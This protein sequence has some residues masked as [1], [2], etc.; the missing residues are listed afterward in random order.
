MTTA[1]IALCSALVIVEFVFVPLYLKKM[2]PI[3]NWGSLCY[4]M[5]CA[6][7][8]VLLAVT[9]TVSTGGA[10]KYSAVMLAGFAFSWLGDLMLHIPKPTRLFFLIGTFFFGMAHVFYCLAYVSAQKAYFPE[11]PMFY[12]WEITLTTAL[13]ITYFIVCLIRKVPFG[14]LIIPMVIYGFFV[15]MMTLKSTELAIRLLEA[16]GVK[17]IVPAILLLLGGLM[18]I[19]SDGSLALLTVDTRYKK[20]KLKVFNSVTYFGAQVCLAFTILF[21]K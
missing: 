8:Y 13:V 16:Q 19:Q 21:I 3:K 14:V 12:W 10:N 20:F 7:A 11:N 1:S 4:K 18:F 6:T 15:T 17:A 5:V 9:L 2:W